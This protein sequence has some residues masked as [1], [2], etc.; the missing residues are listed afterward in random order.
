MRMP[1]SVLAFFFSLTLVFA[2]SP[3]AAQAPHAASPAALDAALQQR[4]AAA[5]A[6][7]ETVLRLLERDEVKAIA[8]KAGIDLKKAAS[9]AHRRPAEARSVEARFMLD[10]A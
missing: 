1:A 7:R 9:A 4:A 2:V 8:G 6:D 5:N 10:P 3:A